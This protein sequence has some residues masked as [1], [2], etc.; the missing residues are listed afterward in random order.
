M[1]RIIVA[2]GLLFLFTTQPGL[3]RQDRPGD[4]DYYVLSLSWS[5]TYCGSRA[6]RRDRS[7]CAAGRRFAFV[8]HGLWPQF[9]RGW[10]G[11]CNSRERWVGRRQIRTMLDI[12]PSKK[13]IIHEW[14]KHG[15]CSGLSQRA[16]FELT[17]QLFGKVKIPARYLSPNNYVQ[18]SPH[19]LA[20]DFVNTNLDLDHSMIAVYCGNS[21]NSRRNARLSEIRIC[22]SRDGRL[23]GCGQNE[24]RA[25]RA[26]SIT[27]PPVR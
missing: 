26:R 18:V 6:G 21:R 20:T 3:A 2:V 14:K 22:F 7:Q 1:Y 5:P 13:L 15:S 24:R 25:C 23:T 10:P 11:N 17:R 16:Y 19:Q 9:N 27:M 12:M 8:V 4:F